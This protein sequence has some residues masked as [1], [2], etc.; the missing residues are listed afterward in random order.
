VNMRD[1]ARVA[2]ASRVLGDAAKEEGAA[3]RA[4]LGQQMLDAGVERVRVHNDD[5][6]YGTVVCTPGRR[7]AAIVNDDAFTAW[8]VDKETG[9][10]IPGMA[11]RQGDPYLTVRPSSDAKERMKTSL[12]SHGLLMLGWAEDGA[13]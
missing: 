12:A 10:V 11:M 8:V 7:S 6:D 13:A 1:L 2:M 9:E 3:A 4:A 5:V